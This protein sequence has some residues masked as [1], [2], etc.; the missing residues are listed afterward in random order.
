MINLAFISLAVLNVL[1]LSI[2]VWR[3]REHD[4]ERR[5]LYDRIMANSLID[6]NIGKKLPTPGRNFVKDGIIKG[7]NTMY[8]TDTKNEG[9]I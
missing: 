7:Y 8:G 1:L 9:D 6:L 4:K 2:F 5:D 3:E